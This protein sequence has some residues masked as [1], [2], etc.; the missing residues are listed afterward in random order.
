MRTTTQ[1]TATVAVLGTG[2]MGA[3]IARNLL[4][5]GY[6]VRVWNRSPGKA[7]ALATLGARIASSPAEAASDADFLITMLT[8]GDAVETTMTGSE[9]A[10]AALPA[11]AVWVQMSTVG[12][13][14]TERLAA[15]ARGRVAFVDAPVSGSSEPAERG[16]LLIL[17]SGDRALHTRVQPLFDV[18]GRRTLWLD[19]VGD[20][21]SL[22]LALN[23]W[24]AVL[25]EGMA[26]TLSLTEALGLDPALLLATLAESP[27]GSAYATAKG[28]AMVE[29]DFTPGFPLRHADKDAAL[30]LQAA[31]R[32]GHDLP[33]TGA[34][35]KR[36]DEAISAGHAEDDVAAAVTAA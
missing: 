26:E 9:G 7:E 35:L 12:V 31:E 25:V 19:R 22:K 34:L 10:L 20:G 13:G 33:L 2:V 3:P 17:A 32:L 8:D 5:A 29:R 30:V 24:L 15:L 16:E 36:W 11:D 4:R 1:T 23:N 27:L 28:R 14:A 6:P 18:L 21:S